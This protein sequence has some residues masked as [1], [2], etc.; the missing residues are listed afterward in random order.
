VQAEGEVDAEGF[1]IAEVEVGGVEEGEGLGEDVELEGDVFEAG[2]LGEA[3][4]HFVVGGLQA[5]RGGQGGAGEREAEVGRALDAVRQG[6]DEGGPL[7]SVRGAEVQDVDA[8]H[9]LERLQHRAVGRCVAEAEVWREVYESRQ[10]VQAP[11]SLR[12]LH[13]CAHTL[14]TLI[15][16]SVQTHTLS[17]P[18]NS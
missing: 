17:H 7:H 9:P 1:A 18:N 11:P 5:G 2:V 14:A 3:E 12:P 10:L 13:F 16:T 8:R 15:S 6:F 4:A